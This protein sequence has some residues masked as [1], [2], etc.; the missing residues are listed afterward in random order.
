MHHHDRPKT[1]KGRGVFLSA[2]HAR[3]AR[4]EVRT[5][6]VWTQ[7]SCLPFAWIQ[8]TEL[9]L[10]GFHRKQHLFL[11]PYHQWVSGKALMN[12]ICCI[13]HPKVKRLYFLSTV[14]MGS[15]IVG[16]M[17]TKKNPCERNVLR[18]F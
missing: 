2:C 6:L 8:R 5:G 12:G 9:T 15:V 17:S 13:C 18:Y 10:L 1:L 16:V 11:E 14:A 3:C 4:M 7:L